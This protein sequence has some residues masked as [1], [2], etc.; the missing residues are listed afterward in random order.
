MPHLPCPHCSHTLEVAISRAG[1]EIP[2][3]ACG[4]TVSVPKLGQLRQLEG[5]D[6]APAASAAASSA[7]LGR[8]VVFAALMAVAALAGCVA[9][10]CFVRYAA[11]KPPMTTAEHIAE[12][13]ETYAQLPAAELVREWQQMDQFHPEIATPHRY[14]LVADEKAG[15]LQQG[16]IA[17]S[18]AIIAALT[19]TVII[20]LRPKRI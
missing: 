15:W 12:V 1:A 19:A 11:I 10:F 9:A 16:L 8:R 5:Q 14:K 13:E 18:I 7:V 3:P 17:L 20:V 4:K 6:E 2:C